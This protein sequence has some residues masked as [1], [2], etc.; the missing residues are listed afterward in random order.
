MKSDYRLWQLGHDEFE[1]LVVHMCFKLLGPGTVAFADGRDGGRDARFTGTAIRYPSPT[2]PWSGKF[3]I[4]AKHTSSPVASCSDPDFHKNK[5]STLALELQK[6]INLKKD[7]FLNNYILFTNRSAPGSIDVA[8]SEFKTNSGIVNF[9]IIAKETMHTII[10]AE[11]DL[12]KICDL[13]R[14]RGP[15]RIDPIDLKEIIEEFHT[16]AAIKKV[17]LSGMPSFSYL[18]ISE[19][20]RINDL[21]AAY[22]A[23]MTS[24]SE[25]Y[26]NDI[27]RF[28]KHPANQSLAEKYQDLAHD[29]NAKVFSRRQEFAGFST[30]LSHLYEQVSSALRSLPGKRRLISAF[31]HYMYFN[32]DLGLKK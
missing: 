13:D 9:E 10:D 17:D 31:L 28:L 3:I 11:P 4:Q 15:L 20:N 5:S 30:V 8:I 12:I 22:F 19:K 27:D 24:E 16:N 26:F 21:D 7:G 18:N 23:Y 6:V 1:R 29:F 25:P 32:C 14:L 2:A